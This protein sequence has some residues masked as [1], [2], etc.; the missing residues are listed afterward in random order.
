MNTKLILLRGPAAVGK[1]TISR[2]LV[3]E[4]KDAAYVSEDM[5]RGWL[6]VKRGE[7]NKITYKNSAILI[8]NMIDKLL[9]L[10]KY[11]YIV[12]EGLFPD[13]KVLETY[14]KYAKKKIF[15]IVLFQL[16]AKKK[17]LVARNTI[18]RGHIVRKEAIGIHWE[19][20][21]K[22]HKE[23]IFIDA[24]KPVEESVEQIKNL[25]YKK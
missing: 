25:I 3:K 16:Q 21:K 18:E 20:F 13:L 12:I 7:N 14:F 24:T 4:L 10:D 19:L 22:S 2:K 6:Q 11:K 1:T 17:D 15:D 5:F 9:E 8:Q 23:T